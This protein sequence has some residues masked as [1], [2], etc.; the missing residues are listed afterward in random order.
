MGF[1]LIKEIFYTIKF[2]KRLE[3]AGVVQASQA[4]SKSLALA[5][6]MGGMPQNSGPN[7]MALHTDEIMR[8]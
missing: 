1:F 4:V 6:A 7:F 5:A 8:L 3:R 2:F